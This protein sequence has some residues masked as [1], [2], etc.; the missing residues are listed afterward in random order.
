M[1]LYS[2]RAVCTVVVCCVLPFARWLWISSD[3][4]IRCFILA[5]LALSFEIDRAV[6][7]RQVRGSRLAPGAMGAGPG[8]GRACLLRAALAPEAYTVIRWRAAGLIQAGSAPSLASALCD[9]A[10]RQASVA[11]TSS[12]APAVH[13]RKQMVKWWMVGACRIEGCT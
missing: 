9:V 3:S 13:E 1:S 5:V 10:G 7:R 6:P 4:K 11:A 2:L 12:P 8:P